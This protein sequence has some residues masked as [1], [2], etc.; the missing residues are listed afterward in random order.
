M[1]LHPVN[2]IAHYWG[3]TFQNPIGY[4]VYSDTTLNSA[5]GDKLQ[6]ILPNFFVSLDSELAAI[7][8]PIWDGM[9]YITSHGAS[10]WIKTTNR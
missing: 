8:S 6:I 9:P 7:C 5:E 3:K 10:F 4:L 1:I 2:I